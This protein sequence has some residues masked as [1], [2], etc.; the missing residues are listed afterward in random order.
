MTNPMLQFFQTPLVPL[1]LMGF[2]LTLTNGV[3]FMFLST[4]AVVVFF[5]P[6][7]KPS[8]IPGRWQALVESIME[9]LADMIGP[10]DTR[11]TQGLL[12]I[13][14]SLFFIIMFGNVMGLFP[15]A[16]TFTSQLVVTLS[17]A[18]AIFILSIILGFWKRG[19]GF[20]RQFVP[21]GVSLWLYP[22]II[23]IEII[24]FFT[25]P[26]SLG[27][28]LFVNMV[29]GHSIMVVM[30]SFAAGLSVITWCVG[31][32]NAGPFY[33]RSGYC[34]VTGVRFCCVEQLIPT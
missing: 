11:L 20:L 27:L 25:R 6:L 33:V 15:G 17:M 13:I 32:V 8:T 26:F 9:M 28:R 30:A 22:M 24:S 1:S 14:A 10:F 34:P 31:I 4:V 3:L 18:M 2:D 7:W 12:P 5:T 29:A 16:F 21:K 19:F 23:P